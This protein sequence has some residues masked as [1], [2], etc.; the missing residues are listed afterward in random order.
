LR[1]ESESFAGVE[2]SIRKVSLL[3]RIE[4]VAKV[5]ELTLNHEFLRAGDPKDQL[6][7]TISELLV[8]RLYLE[9]GVVDLRGL[10]IDGEA[11]SVQLLIE[12]GPEALAAEISGA[13]RTHLEFSETERKNS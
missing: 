1:F 11:A 9:W 4:L 8:Q 10:T 12:R 5:R 13:I 2:F 3:Q 6:E 7:A